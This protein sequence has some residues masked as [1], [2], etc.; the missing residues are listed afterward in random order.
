[1]FFQAEIINFSK[2][3][4]CI[5]TD[6]GFSPQAEIVH[7]SKRLYY[8]VHCI[9]TDEGFFQAEIV[10]TSLSAELGPCVIRDE[11]LGNW[12]YGSGGGGEWGVMSHTLNN[13]YVIRS[14]VGSNVE[15]PDTFNSITQ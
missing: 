13:Y 15:N 10:F 2:R 7:F 4:H 3:P 9:V 12:R 6:E 1:M 11:V 14:W 8:R 5:V